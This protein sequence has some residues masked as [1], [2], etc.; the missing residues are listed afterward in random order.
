V[1]CSWA[2]PPCAQCQ[3]SIHWASAWSRPCGACTSD[4]CVRHAPSPLSC[5]PWE[6]PSSRPHP[7]SAS[8][9]QMCSSCSSFSDPSWTCHHHLACH[10][11]RQAGG[12]LELPLQ[13]IDGRGHGNDL[14]ITRRSGSPSAFCTKVIELGLCHSHKGLVGEGC[15][16]PV[17]VVLV[18]PV[19]LTL[20]MVARDNLI[21]QEE[22]PN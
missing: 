4:R 15:E 1:T 17:E 22:D 7:S 20:E 2:T 12:K 6:G 13:A 14:V 19:D 3:S 8:H 10:Q 21:G 9:G 5:C 16:F 18:H 11:Q